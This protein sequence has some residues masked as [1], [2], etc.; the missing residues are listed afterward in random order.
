M[1]PAIDQTLSARRSYYDRIDWGAVEPYQL[2]VRRDLTALLPKDVSNILDVG[3]GN[4]YIAN[5]LA[6][7]Y[8][9]VGVDIST[10]ALRHL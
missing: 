4:G 1:N 5:A 6:G 3:C 9:V 10:A 7:R 8:S 2:E